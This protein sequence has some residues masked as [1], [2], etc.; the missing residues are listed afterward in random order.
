MSSGLI[1]VKVWTRCNW[2]NGGGMHVLFLPKTISPDLIFLSVLS[3]VTTL[4]L[5]WLLFSSDRIFSL[6]K[7]FNMAFTMS[8]LIVSRDTP[9]PNFFIILTSSLDLLCESISSVS[10]DWSKWLYL[11]CM[12][13]KI[14]VIR[15]RLNTEL[16]KVVKLYHWHK[17]MSSSQNQKISEMLTVG[18]Y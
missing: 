2:L 14:D 6:V 17:V 13:M 15:I 5:S 4:K 10:C 11:F 12:N 16:S 9:T 3:P 7:L 18:F 8:R 1:F